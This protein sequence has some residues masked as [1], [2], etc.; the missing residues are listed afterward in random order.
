MI[1]EVAMINYHMNDIKGYLKFL[2]YACTRNF[3][4]TLKLVGS[5]MIRPRRSGFIPG[6]PKI[7]LAGSAMAMEK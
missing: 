4:Q 3:M 6:L 1:M 7:S 2:S 5:H